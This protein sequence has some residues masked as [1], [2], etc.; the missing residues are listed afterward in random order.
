MTGASPGMRA[1]QAG[2][3]LLDISSASLFR[4]SIKKTSVWREAVLLPLLYQ[5]P[6]GVKASFS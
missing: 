3:R 2:E 5:F 6:D 4:G 1:G